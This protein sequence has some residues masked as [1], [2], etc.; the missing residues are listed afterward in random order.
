MLRRDRSHCVH[1]R[2]EVEALEM[3]AVSSSGCPLDAAEA[4]ATDQL[5]DR[6]LDT[7]QHILLGHAIWPVLGDPETHTFKVS[8]QAHLSCCLSRCD[9]SADLLVLP[10]GLDQHD[11]Q[12]PLLRPLRRYGSAHLQW[13]WTYLQGPP[14]CK[15]GEF[16]RAWGLIVLTVR[17]PEQHSP[18]VHEERNARRPTMPQ[19]IPP[20]GC[21]NSQAANLQH[22]PDLQPSSSKVDAAH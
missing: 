7:A 9:L 15:A 13:P 1:V 10:D 22:K 18:I 6:R 3:V 11:S 5:Q 2:T 4:G 8:L 21:I 14:R 12:S 19:F 16:K 17:F 20:L